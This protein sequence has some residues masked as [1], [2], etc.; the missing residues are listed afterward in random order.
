MTAWP[1]SLKPIRKFMARAR[2]IEAVQ[3]VV[4][5]YCNYHSLTKAIE[6]R[7]AADTSANRFVT[8][9]LEKCET[10]KSALPPG[11]K[12]SHRAAV[13]EFALTVFDRADT[14]DRNELAT[15][16]TAL[17]FYAAMCFLEVCSVFGP[18]SPELDERLRY[19][20]WKAADITKAL[21]EGRKPMPGAPG[22]AEA[23]EKAEREKAAA[24]AE[25]GPTP[26]PEIQERA[27]QPA[28]DTSGVPPAPPVYEYESPA[29]PLYPQSKPH[30][31]F[32][33]VAPKYP[34]SDAPS[35]LPAIRKTPP[36]APA[37][38]LNTVKGPRSL[39]IGGLPP[40]SL[41]IAAVPNVPSMNIPTTEQPEVS[42]FSS[43]SFYESIKQIESSL[44][45]GKEQTRG[46][47]V[48]PPE[49]ETSPTAV[50]PPMP[51]SQPRATMPPPKPAP[52]PM[53]SKPAV[54]EPAPVPPP[55]VPVAPRAVAA[56][57]PAVA[58][59][60]NFR[61]SIKQTQ[62][63]QRLAK[64][65]ASALDFQDVKTAVQNMER[66]LGLL[67]GSIQ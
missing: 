30:T 10:A 23:R 52:A 2:E 24:E 11:D 4:A 64:Y 25:M 40:P 65:A 59:D 12:D 27:F 37:L 33:P 43:P 60:P 34:S 32:P 62:E 38:D 28:Q 13:I 15:K 55:V 66:A 56:A 45:P 54:P 20:K 36:Q 14:D 1:E 41:D 9:L 58:I 5:Y 8:G 51:V 22:E 21:K 44:P 50:S 3:P 42:A 35:P 47:P 48:P 6:L 7:D 18:L 46:M 39:D 49:E 19:A 67:R 17:T 31:D 26:P 61:P 57:P 63:A 53:P 16:D 29:E